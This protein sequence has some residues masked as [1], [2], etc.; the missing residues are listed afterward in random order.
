MHIFE[1]VI[2]KNFTKEIA[3]KKGGGMR[4]IFESS[5]EEVLKMKLKVLFGIY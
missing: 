5:M 3:Q 4:A 1:Y 2:H